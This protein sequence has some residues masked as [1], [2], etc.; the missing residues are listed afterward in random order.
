MLNLKLKT[1]KLTNKYSQY[2]LNKFSEIKSN[3]FISIQSTYT[4]VC[5]F[6]GV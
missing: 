6:D 4:S 2:L 5:L 1:T 3:R